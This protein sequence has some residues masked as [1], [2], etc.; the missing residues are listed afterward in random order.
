[1]SQTTDNRSVPQL[2]SDLARE[3]TTL[4]RKEG[5]LIRAELSEKTS[6]LALGLGE[7]AAG[8]ICLLVALNVLAGA[9]VV[10]IARIGADA[11]D[12]AIQDTGIGLG[13]ASLIVGVLLAAIG[14]F[15][16]KKG[17]A[18]M[19]N[20]TPERSVNQVAQDASLVKEQ[21]R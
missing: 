1:M 12:P 4:F 7:A 9:L 3:L 20:L 16:V 21:V 11:A 13:W 17:A 15:L 6:Q 18:N 2:L 14:A 5:Q 19:S 8:A 10:A